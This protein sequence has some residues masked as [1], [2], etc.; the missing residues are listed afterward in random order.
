[1]GKEFGNLAFIRGIIYY[2]ISPHEQKPFARAIKYGI[3]NFIPRTSATILTWLPLII[4]RLIIFL[5]F[6]GAIIIY[7]SVEENHRLRLRKKPED[8]I[9]DT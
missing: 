7:K 2:Q 5:A 8:Y 9:N 1:M 3:P 4:L 6:L